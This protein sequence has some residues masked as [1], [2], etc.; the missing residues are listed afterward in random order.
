MEQIEGLI[1]PPACYYFTTLSLILLPTQRP[2][3]A[4]WKGLSFYKPPTH[5]AMMYVMTQ[6]PPA[7]ANKQKLI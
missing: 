2:D 7:G 5:P 3:F 6:A 1:R 4:F